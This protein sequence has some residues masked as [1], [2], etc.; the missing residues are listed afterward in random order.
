MNN[1]YLF[2]NLRVDYNILYYYN[3]NIVD[4]NNK[5]FIYLNNLIK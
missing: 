3:N 1:Y 4:Y 5:L 2:Q